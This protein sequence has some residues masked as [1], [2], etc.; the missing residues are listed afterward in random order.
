MIRQGHLSW[1]PE[2]DGEL[3]RQSTYAVQCRTHLDCVGSEIDTH[4]LNSR[5]IDLS[6]KPYDERLFAR[7]WRA[8]EQKMRTVAR[9]YLQC[10]MKPLKAILYSPYRAVAIHL[11]AIN[12]DSVLQSSTPAF[13]G[14]FRI[15]D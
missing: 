10:V 11:E 9:R 4:L 2:R 12:D 13:L 7:A 5:P 6:Q 8:I 1:M 14:C 3:C 15:P